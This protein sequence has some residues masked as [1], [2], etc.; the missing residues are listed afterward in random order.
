MQFNPNY[1]TI[2]RNVPC[3]YARKR[4]TQQC[5]CISCL[6]AN[7]W[8]SGETDHFV[9]T[10]EFDFQGESND[11]LSFR[12]GTEI[13]VAPKGKLPP[14]HQ[15]GFNFAVITC[16]VLLINAMWGG[17]ACFYD[18]AGKPGFM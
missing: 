15:I 8:A 11:E 18:M 4:V 1:L 10:A 7:A 14:S 9:A 6:G 2:Y 16:T 13:I 5:I 3:I 12:R 17:V